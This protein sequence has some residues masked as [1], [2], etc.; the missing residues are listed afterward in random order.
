MAAT[1]A[2]APPRTSVMMVCSSEVSSP[3]PSDWPLLPDGCMQAAVR[4]LSGAGAAAGAVAVGTRLEVPSPDRCRCAK[5][6][7]WAMGRRRPFRFCSRALAAL[8]AD[9]S[10]SGKQWGQVAAQP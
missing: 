6:G 10:V 3:I 8:H 9:A 4:P 1:L 5:G 7:A 2:L